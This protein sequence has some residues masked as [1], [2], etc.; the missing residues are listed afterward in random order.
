MKEFDRKK[1]DK[2][3]SAG[4]FIQNISDRIKDSANF[5]LFFEID[6]PIAEMRQKIM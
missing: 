4:V 1:I 2:A 5:L 6:N 3:N